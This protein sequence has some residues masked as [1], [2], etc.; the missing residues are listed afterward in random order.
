MIVA[1]VADLH[2]DERKGDSGESLDEQVERLLWIGD[3]AYKEGAGLVLVAGDVFD[4][5]SSPAERNAAIDVFTSWASRMPVICVY[6]NHD[7]PG[8]LDFLPWLRS[9][10]PIRVFSRPDIAVGPVVVAC[11]PWPRKSWLAAAGV[12]DVNAAAVAGMRSILTGF[13]AQFRDLEAP[14]VLLAHAELGCALTD[15][16]QPL[17]GRA[18]L[19]LSEADLLWSGADVVCLGHIHKHQVLAG[20][21]IV[22][23]GSPRQTT[24][25][26]DA[27]KGY[28]LIDLSDSPPAIEHRRAPGR[29]LVTV[30]A[31]WDGE[32]MDFVVEAE[33]LPR[34]AIV[35]VL[36]EFPEDA[37]A[38]AAAQIESYVGWLDGRTVKRDLRVLPTSRVRS[39]GI[40]LARTNADRVKAW[41][42]ASGE[43]PDRAEAIL[44]KL[45]EIEVSVLS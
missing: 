44:E 32:A 19:E 4:H 26:E 24:F 36:A 16:G 43:T 11:L 12:E 29:E 22:Y 2:I 35:R 5:L 18:D 38:K 45:G 30:E 37:R 23:A 28:C 25:G 8:D 13:A 39:E 15:S 6:G 31:R 14:R 1:H 17:V 20:G 7:R 40:R 9:K 34:D 3:D 33:T 21:R 27:Q 42:A 10:Y 41:W